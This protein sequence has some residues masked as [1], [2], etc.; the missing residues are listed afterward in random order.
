ETP[1]EQQSPAR[2]I[3][4][5]NP[6]PFEPIRYPRPWTDRQHTDTSRSLPRN[7]PFARS[8]RPAAARDR[9]LPVPL[10]ATHTFQQFVDRAIRRSSAFGFVARVR[11][12]PL[13]P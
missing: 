5:S 4:F 8:V 2:G 3:S 11:S 9:H 1:H 7:L 12:P 13:C 10:G 6:K